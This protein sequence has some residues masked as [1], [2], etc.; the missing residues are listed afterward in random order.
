MYDKICPHLNCLVYHPDGVCTCDMASS[1]G[2]CKGEVKE[3]NFD[4]LKDRIE[5]LE[6]PIV[7]D[8][9]K[10]NCERAIEQ[11]RKQVVDEVRGLEEMK[12]EDVESSRPDF[13]GND[14]NPLEV[15]NEFRVELRSQLDRLEKE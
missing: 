9:I 7:K 3:N 11:T 13:Y 6:N 10:M 15:R 2:I 14:F 8:L 12:D 5:L 4:S 1:C